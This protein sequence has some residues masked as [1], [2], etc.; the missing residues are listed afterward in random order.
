MSVLNRFFSKNAD[1][2]IE[3]LETKAEITNDL[4]KTIFNTS[5]GTRTINTISN[6]AGYILVGLIGNLGVKVLFINITNGNVSVTD[7]TTN[8]AFS[9]Q[10][11]TFGYNN[12]THDLTITTVHQSTLA[13][14]GKGHLI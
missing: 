4:I 6:Y 10:Y 8:T 11:L 5:S 12:N 7:L 1:D 13:L 14:V 9:S 3:T 2:R